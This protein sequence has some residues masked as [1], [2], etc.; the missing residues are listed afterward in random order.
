MCGIVAA[1]SK[2]GGV[3][4]EAVGC[5]EVDIAIAE[6]Q[7]AAMGRRIPPGGRSLGRSRGSLLRCDLP[8]EVSIPPRRGRSLDVNEPT[9]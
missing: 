4:A 7:A 1:V 3:R 9:A 2:A 8:I 6:E 5:D